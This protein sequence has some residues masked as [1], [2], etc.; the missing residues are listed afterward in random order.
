MLAAAILLAGAAAVLALEPPG[1]VILRGH[2]GAVFAAQMTPD[3]ERVVTAATDG[4]VRLWDAVTGAEIR[5]FVGHTGPVTGVAISGDGRTLA[6]SSQDNSVRVWDLPL[7]KPLVVR[8]AHA[9]DGS[10]LALASD[11]RML[12]TGGRDPVARL[13]DTQRLREAAATPAGAA[14]QAAAE[15]VG[16]SLGEAAAPAR[17]IAWR[18]DGAQYALA[19]A[20]GRIVLGSP[21][22]ETPLG[23]LGVHGGGVAA[24][25]FVPGNP[26][27]LLSA[28]LDGTLRL[29]QAAPVAE[30]SLTMATGIRDLLPLPGQPVAAVAR[31]DG[32]LQLVDIATMQPVRDLPTGAP[33][34]ALA[35]TSDGGMLVIGDEGGKV[36]WLNSADG[37]DRGAIG[38]HDGAVLDVAS[39]PD[40]G[41]VFSAG[42][43][44]TLRQ[45]VRPAAEVVLDGHSQGV[46][47]AV[48]AADGQ[49]FA[50]TGDDR[51]LRIW[52]GAGQPLR[53]VGTH[54]QPLS[55]L[56]ISADGRGLAAGDVAGAITLWNPQDGAAFGAV[57]AHR[58]AILAIAH[59]RDGSA[60]WSAGA[61]GTLKRTKMP[62]ALPRTLAGHAAPVRAI[63]TTADGRGAFTAGQ[64]GVVRQWD[65]ASGQTTRTFGE[66]AGAVTALSVAD[67]GSLVAAVSETG[68]VRAWRVADGAAAF[69]ANL[70]GVP[71]RDVVILP[72][73]AGTTRLVTVG[74]DQRLR[75]WALAAAV[76]AD[77][78][79]VVPAQELVLPE[80]G[81]D[82]IALAADGSWLAASGAGRIVRRFRV[83]VDAVTPIDGGF[84]AGA[85]RITDVAFSRDGG[86]FAASG[87]DGKVMLWDARTILTAPG[88]VSPE[89]TLVHSAAVR[90]ITFDPGMPARHL[91]SASDDGSVASWDLAS[92]RLMERFAA[93]GA[94]ATVASGGGTVLAAGA[95]PAIRVWT[96]AVDLTVDMAPGAAPAAAAALVTLPGKRGLA[97]LV[98]GEREVRR[99]GAAG[100]P[101]P[102]LPGTDGALA[103]FAT[104]ADGHRA[105]VA[106][107]AG[108]AWTWEL[109]T[110]TLQGPITLG[111]GVT[112][113]SLALPVAADAPGQILV[114]DSLPRLRAIDPKS[115][116][117]VEEMVLPAPAVVAVS[118][119]AAG[120]GPA[121][122][123][124]L[125][126]NWV[127]F[128]AQPRGSLKSRCWVR[129]LLETPAAMTAVTLSA[130][131][132]KVCGAG[133][134]GRIVVFKT[135]DG[136]SERDIDAGSVAIREL[137]WL[138][139]P[140]SIA[141][142]CADGTVRIWSLD[143]EPAPRVLAGGPPLVSLAVSADGSRLA[144]LSDTGVVHQWAL[145]SDTPLQSFP[146][147]AAG[148]GRVR[149]LADN[150]SM[151][152]GSTDRTIRQV[153]GTALRSMRIAA[154]PITA[155]ATAGNQVVVAA[156]D[157]SVRSV[158]VAGTAPPRM[159]VEA[160]GTP[161]VIAARPDG[162]RLA[163][164]DGSGKLGIWDPAG[165]RQLEGLTVQSRAL[166]LCFSGDG[167]KIVAAT[168]PAPGVQP[169]LVVFGPPPA[170]A[171]AAPGKEF[172]LHQ[173]IAMPAPVTASAV[174]AEGRGVWCLHDDGVL[175]EWAVAALDSLRR[176][177]AGSP[178]LT[179]AISRDGGTVVSGGNDQSVRVWDPIGGQQRFQ[180]TGHAGPVLALALTPDDAMVV[181]AS[182]DLTL[183]LWDVAG[184]RA[185]KQLTTTDEAVYSL[186]VDPSGRTVAAGGADRSI[187]LL[188]ILGGGIERSLRGHADFVHA[189]AFNSRGTR[190][191][192]YGYSGVLKIWNPADGMLLHD[193]VVGRIGNAASWGAAAGSTGTGGGAG[194]VDDVVVVACG[195]GTVR[196]VVVPVAVR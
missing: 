157:G 143:A 31:E 187:H 107:S 17:A 185:L 2:E 105:V 27:Q 87:D 15:G 101:L 82:R 18:A 164:A 148:R 67:D 137:S 127:S 61:D 172:V 33:A 37:S 66:A 34:N 150:L 65:L 40:G 9:H 32:G 43:D 124:A 118:T 175:R 141:A 119:G 125:G 56:A 153:K 189:V 180:M 12:L 191:L 11:G 96:P 42:A 165:W 117:T 14:P 160:G 116:R 151:L 128:G 91:T 51:T 163:V 16:L 144:T 29:W 58:G 113:L 88:E 103:H 26:Q 84:T 136:V 195:D 92:G 178:V 161:V 158:D 77:G 48:A 171:S 38:G 186:S 83:G 159:I 132:T 154:G 6:T 86:W 45:W 78:K 53:T 162:Q 169:T 120:P 131:G 99:F 133:E 46:K 97:V 20:V 93:S 62:L 76:V 192:S 182:G 89:K 123:G 75:L 44:G 139:Q 181:S 63:V 85:A 4:T 152:S 74:D 90:G 13:W 71:Q 3:G 184:G 30:R 114:A 138:A 121:G 59:E 79:D 156:G 10:V 22:L 140:P 73:V 135:A 81:T 122:T 130:D 35:A 188:D 170:P 196:I 166:S 183:R 146:G 1:E 109:A 193:T 190:L 145:A 174:D 64:D 41:T 108:Q 112:A 129:T 57:L 25:S 23:T 167:R 115:G 98:G 134:S 39:T 155:L 80:A 69:V 47:L 149:F 5:R 142:A 60:L 106:N 179:V 100:Q 168:A 104:S 49:W 19:D 28:G 95:D 126:R 8:P 36:R 7:T 21:Y 55:A 68:S 70:P 194:P 94:L 177:D 24:T 72:T 147:H 176:F 50:T 173:S 102:A 54:A 111:A 110:D 52:N